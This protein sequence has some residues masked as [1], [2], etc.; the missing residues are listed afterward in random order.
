PTIR[1]EP[2][3]DF[4]A[5]ADLEQGA[6]AYAWLVFTSP[7]GVKAFFN[8]FYKLYDDAREIGGARI[9]AIGP[10]TAKEVKNF[11]LQVDLQPEESV[12]EALIQAFQK[13]GTVENQ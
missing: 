3:I 9:A 13:E 12:A 10:G 8:L 1:I 7:N 5:F 2:P 4:R 6:H 11:R